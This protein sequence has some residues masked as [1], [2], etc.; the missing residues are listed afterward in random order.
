[1]FLVALFL[2]SEQEPSRRLE[3]TA[4][5]FSFFF[6][7][8]KKVDRSPGNS[9]LRLWRDIFPESLQINSLINDLINYSTTKPCV[10]SFSCRHSRAMSSSDSPEASQRA[11]ATVDAAQA[12]WQ[13]TKRGKGRVAPRTISGIGIASNVPKLAAVSHAYVYHAVV[14]KGL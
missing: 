12:G 2:S 14:L 5:L 11:D 6:P 10:Y 8:R 7:D 13:Q 1:M 4:Q 9:I 3:H